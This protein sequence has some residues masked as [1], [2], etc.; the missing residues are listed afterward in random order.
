MRRRESVLPV[1]NLE[2][3]D[4]L[5]VVSNRRGLADCTSGVTPGRGNVG[6]VMRQGGSKPAC[7]QVEA[8]S[9]GR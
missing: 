7:E 6:P 2:V 4:T 1:F 3:T 9:G 5:L 8:K